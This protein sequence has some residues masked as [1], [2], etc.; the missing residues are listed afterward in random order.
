[1]RNT[2][3]L[4]LLLLASACAAPQTVQFVPSKKSP[5]ELR[6]AQTR[7]IAADSESVMRGVVATLHDLGYRITRVEAGAHTISATRQTTLRMGVVVRP[8]SPSQSIIRANATIVAL[9]REAQVDSPEFYRDDFFLPLGR[10]M[11]REVFALPDNAAAPDPVRPAAE[12]NT[13]SDREA[14]VKA[15]AKPA[16]GSPPTGAKSP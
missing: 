10:M 14:A 15:A 12:L 1:M 3:V 9:R 2:L 11:S 4:G 16:G 7:M 13:A 8:D 6:A 5:V